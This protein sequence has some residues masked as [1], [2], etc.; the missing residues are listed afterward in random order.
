MMATTGSE[1]DT[2]KSPISTQLGPTQGAQLGQ[3]QTQSLNA[4][5][6]MNATPTAH[7]AAPQ[8]SSANAISSY[9]WGPTSSGSNSTGAAFKTPQMYGDFAALGGI[10]GANFPYMN[11][12]STPSHVPK[13]A[14][15]QPA[16][17]LQ[18]PADSLYS[19][20]NQTE[21]RNFAPRVGVAGLMPVAV[22]PPSFDIGRRPTKNTGGSQ[23]AAPDLDP[24][25]SPPV[26]GA[27]LYGN[28]QALTLAS[29][30]EENHL[31]LIARQ[32]FYD[33]VPAEVRMMRSAQ[34][35]QLT[36][37]PTCVPIQEVGLATENFPFMESATQ[38]APV[39]HG[40]VKLKNVCR[41]HI[42][43]LSDKAVAQAD[44]HALY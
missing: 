3:I 21:P 37:G 41:P 24:F 36:G 34:L 28:S 12:D 18:L 17:A 44:L 29:V 35:N 19:Q 4:V 6:N 20:Y 11:P 31:A 26:R 14:G 13:K 40:V 27:S 42:H 30:P 8:F 1:A 39:G 7:G 25:L 23:F 9:P 10:L 16:D 2:A 32:A 15:K 5:A 22:P 43:P 38:A 33:Q